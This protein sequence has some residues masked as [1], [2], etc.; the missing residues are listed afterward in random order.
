MLNKFTK[1][2]GRLC[3]SYLK[4]RVD[5]ILSEY[6]RRSLEQLFISFLCE[7][8]YNSHIQTESLEHT[9]SHGDPRSGQHKQLDPRITFLLR[10]F[11]TVSTCTIF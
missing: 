9:V 7:D 2:K 4:L 8:L 11:T 1:C 5:W 6:K 3:N 10:V